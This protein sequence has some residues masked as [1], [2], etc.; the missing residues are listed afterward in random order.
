MS[1]DFVAEGGRLFVA[2]GGHG[3][4]ANHIATLSSQLMEILPPVPTDYVIPTGPATLRGDLPAPPPNL[5]QE[6]MTAVPTSVVAGLLDPAYRSSMASQFK[7]G[8]TPDWY[9]DLPSGIKDYVS[10]LHAKM[11]SDGITYDGG[12]LETGALDAPEREASDDDSGSTSPSSALASR[13]TGALA[14]GFALA[15]GVLGA[16][17]AL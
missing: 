3:F 10:Q 5:L 17:V 15:M 6:I 2:N 4:H 13:P 12:A 8:K 16:A 9:N 1:F 7:E 11:T 14:G